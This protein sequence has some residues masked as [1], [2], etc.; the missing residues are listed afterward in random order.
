MVVKHRRKR[1][2]VSIVPSVAGEKPDDV[3]C[4]DF[5]FDS[6]ITGK[7]MK[8]LYIVYEHI[9]EC[10]TDLVEYSTTALDCAEQID[11]LAL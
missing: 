6:T 7:P 5:Q 2:G 3:W 8:F 1:I 10:L 4:I 11:V 9:G